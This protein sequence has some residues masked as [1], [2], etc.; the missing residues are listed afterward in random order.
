MPFFRKQTRIIACGDPVAVS[1]YCEQQGKK[2]RSVLVVACYD[3]SE[4]NPIALETIASQKKREDIFMLCLRNAV[5][6]LVC[7]LEG[8][9]GWLL[10]LT[11]AF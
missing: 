11:S 1:A 3:A 8:G 10:T 7:D 6:P 4:S 9:R 5:L 2:V